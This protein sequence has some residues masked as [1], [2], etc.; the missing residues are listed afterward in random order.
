MKKYIMLFFIICPLTIYADDI[1]K[2]LN[3]TEMGFY[4]DIAGVWDIESVRSETGSPRIF[5]WGEGSFVKHSSIIIDFNLWIKDDTWDY[6]GT[7]PYKITD[8]EMIEPYNDSGVVDS[9]KIYKIRLLYERQQLE[10]GLV[11]HLIN[12]STIWFETF[13][14]YK[15]NKGQIDTADRSYSDKKVMGNGD[16]YTG[17]DNLYYKRSGPRRPE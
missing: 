5:S 16:V 11:I 7:I 2:N 14:E 3:T 6:Q 15:L 1:L 12:D 10:S 17:P 13:S 4:Y 9:E 8:I